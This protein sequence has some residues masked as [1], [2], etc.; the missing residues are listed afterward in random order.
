MQ[1]QYY[2]TFI[3]VPVMVN[4]AFLSSLEELK[5]LLAGERISWVAPDRYHITIRFIGDTEIEAVHHIGRSLKDHIEV[6]GKT[7]IRLLRL[8]SFGPR[9]NPRVIWVGFD[10]TRVFEQLK[11]NVDKILETAGI[12]SDPQPFRAHLTL[13]RV[14]SIQNRKGFYDAIGRMEDSFSQKVFI[15][16]LVYYRSELQEGGPLYTSLAEKEFRDQVF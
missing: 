5:K 2:R 15:D 13:G 1:I 4:E 6:P 7:E 9:Q 14:R 12:A 8:G 16:R 3:G 10:Q 11:E